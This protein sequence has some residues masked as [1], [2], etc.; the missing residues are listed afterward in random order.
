MLTEDN[1]Q[2]CGMRS[3]VWGSVWIV[4]VTAA[5]IHTEFERT[6]DVVSLSASAIA[7][8]ALI[9]HFILRK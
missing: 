5:S 1:V 4:T 6:K 3:V 7:L 8:L 9:A 2:R